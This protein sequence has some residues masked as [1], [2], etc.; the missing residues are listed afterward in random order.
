VKYLIIALIISCELISAKGVGL[1]VKE[2]LIWKKQFPYTSDNVE[3]MVCWEKSGSS[4]DYKDDLLQESLGS[5]NVEALK[6]GIV[7]AIKNTWEKY[8][9]IKFLFDP[10]DNK[11]CQVWIHLAEYP[12]DHVSNIGAASNSIVHI[13][14]LMMRY[15]GGREDEISRSDALRMA[16]D[17]QQKRNKL[18]IQNDLD[19]FLLKN[20][21]L[22]AVHEFGHILGLFHEQARNKE[23]V[24]FGEVDTEVAQSEEIPVA[25]YDKY[26][27]MNYNNFDHDYGFAPDGKAYASIRDR[28]G[29]EVPLMPKLSC[30]DVIAIRKLY[31]PPIGKALIA[32]C[33][34]ESGFISIMNDPN[35][36]KNPYPQYA[37]FYIRNKTCFEN[38][39]I[40]IGVVDGKSC[41]ALAKT[42]AAGSDV[43]SMDSNPQQVAGE[44]MN[45][46][47]NW[48]FFANGAVPRFKSTVSL[49][50]HDNQPFLNIEMT[51]PNL[52]DVA[53]GK[54]KTN[55]IGF[56]SAASKNYELPGGTTFTNCEFDLGIGK[57]SCKIEVPMGSGIYDRKKEC[58]CSYSS[59]PT[60]GEYVTYDPTEN[61][62]L[63][64]NTFL[65]Y[66]FD[67]RVFNGRIRREYKVYPN[68]CNRYD[69]RGDFVDD[70]METVTV[71]LDI[72]GELR[73]G[74][75][76]KP[77]LNQPPPKP[78]LPSVSVSDN[79][80]AM[81][82]ASWSQIIDPDNEPVY[83]F[84][85]VQEKNTGKI[86][87]YKSQQQNN[88]SITGLIRNTAYL[89]RV[90]AFDTK[91][92]SYSNF[93]EIKTLDKPEACSQVNTEKEILSRL[94]SDLIRASIPM[95]S[96]R[97]VPTGAVGTL[98]WDYPPAF[99]VEQNPNGLAFNDIPVPS[100]TVQ[101]DWIYIEADNFLNVHLI[102]KGADGIEHETAP[103][104]YYAND[105]S[106]N[107]GNFISLADLWGESS[108]Y[109]SF[110]HWKKEAN[111]IKI[112]V[113]Y[114]SNPSES[115]F[116]AHFGQ[117]QILKESPFGLNYKGVVFNDSYFPGN[118]V[119]YTAYVDEPIEIQVK[120]FT[121]KLQWAGSL[122]GHITEV[123]GARMKFKVGAPIVQGQNSYTFGAINKNIVFAKPIEESHQ[124]N[125]SING[126]PK[127][128]LRRIIDKKGRLSKTLIKGKEYRLDIDGL[129]KPIRKIG[130]NINSI[131]VFLN[132][133]DGA[134]WF[135]A[136]KPKRKNVISVAVDGVICN[137][138]IVNSPTNTAMFNIL[139]N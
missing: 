129:V 64:D 89:V 33:C 12:S 134:Y 50:Y 77:G 104:L 132:W 53:G 27:V 28:D 80:Q 32:P 2:N 66:R 31:P 62:F 121:E 124:I 135:I 84:L 57:N 71:G 78:G 18:L 72:G 103:G 34:T 100:T 108:K 16:S 61:L 96:Y 15:W 120:Y 117:I 52:I 68:T 91:A 110:T 8:A 42:A 14:P 102:F 88:I 60:E 29:N 11:S 107:S 54:V 137:D 126:Y 69:V 51:I 111:L 95:S 25:Y 130:L 93:L 10:P 26:S 63:V 35:A 106:L 98:F 97:K 44:L 45:S 46:Y 43:C 92:Y 41:I 87:T 73:V 83:Y 105:Y 74:K 81:L 3:I 112:R 4:I 122:A 113:S 99:C 90:L 9:G 118:A 76:W 127:P 13:N 131:A 82:S 37:D 49:S 22:E 6:S 119:S 114:K 101:T 123:A 21:Q 5:Q 133:R 47:C 116:R 85:E 125:I 67:Y 65:E 79:G 86:K 139:L 128:V 24:A 17:W 56:Q 48:D 115:M 109:Y 38:G 75:A 36:V 70:I 23:A 20:I 136:P 40:K 55:V 59:S 7:N 19:Y 1:V 39:G 58:F 30:G 94:P 138:L